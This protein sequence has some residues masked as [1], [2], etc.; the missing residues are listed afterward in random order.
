[1]IGYRNELGKQKKENLNVLFFILCSLSINAKELGWLWKD[2][3]TLQQIPANQVKFI[4]NY[5]G[6]VYSFQKIY[7]MSP[8]TKLID[9]SPMKSQR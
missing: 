2:M 3:M 6:I 1:M 8:I 5:R 9:G 4:R 7:H